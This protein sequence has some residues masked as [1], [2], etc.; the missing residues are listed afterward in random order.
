MTGISLGHN[1]IN[2][3]INLI[4]NLSSLTVGIHIVMTAY[5]LARVLLAEFCKHMG[6]LS[7]FCDWKIQQVIIFWNK[8]AEAEPARIIS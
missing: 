4:L 6:N 7:L 2:D 5:Q 3:T 8:Y 1:L